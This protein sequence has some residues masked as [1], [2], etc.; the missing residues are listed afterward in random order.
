M[1][2]CVSALLQR[3]LAPRVFDYLFAKVEE[4]E[5]TVVSRLHGAGGSVVTCLACQHRGHGSCF[6]SSLTG[7]SDVTLSTLRAVYGGSRLHQFWLKCS[8]LFPAQVI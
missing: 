4:E 5:S 3:G 7:T 6:L 8:N 2:G 1:S